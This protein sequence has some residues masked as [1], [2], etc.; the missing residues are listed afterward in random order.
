MNLYYVAKS[1][2]RSRYVHAADAVGARIAALKGEPQGVKC[3]KTVF[4][5]KAF[6]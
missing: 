2:G 3:T 1:N 6:A 5:K 4:V